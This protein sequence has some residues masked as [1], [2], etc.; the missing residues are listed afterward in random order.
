MEASN[1][2]NSGEGHSAQSAL[3][4]LCQQY[5]FPLYSFV[6]RKGFERGQAE[7]LTQSFFTE[8]LEKNRLQHAE[9]S[10]GSFRTFLLTS[11]THFI[12]NH[13]RAENAQKRGGGEKL[14]SIDFDQANHRYSE[15]PGEDLTAEK[16]FERSWALSI[17]D[18]TLSAVEKQYE[19][20]GKQE[21]FAG[22]K[23][24]L[25]GE[26][27]PYQ[28][29]AE[30]TGMREGALKVAV[31][32]LRQRYGQQLRLQIARTVTDPEQVDEEL[33]SL[34]RALE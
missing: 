10:R 22:I 14:L 18:Q 16:I 32:R 24:F 13:W 27:K 20:T 8:L 34:F 15:Q 6:R 29:L 11:L 12:A 4:E 31:H 1:D 26:P 9:P 25:T 7:D 17:L 33:A 5:W 19:E 21:L 2:V 3:S 30:S 23:G 28:D